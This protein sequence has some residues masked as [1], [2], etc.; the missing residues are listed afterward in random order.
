[1]LCWHHSRMALTSPGPEITWRFCW[2]QWVIVE[3]VWNL[4]LQSSKVDENSYMPGYASKIHFTGR[5][6]RDSQSSARRLVF[7]T[8]CTVRYVRASL[9]FRANRWGSAWVAGCV[10]ISSVSAPSFFCF[11]ISLI[12]IEDISLDCRYFSTRVFNTY[13][14]ENNA[15]KICRSNSLAYCISREPLL[16]NVNICFKYEGWVSSRSVSTVWK[17]VD[18]RTRRGLFKKVARCWTRRT[19]AD[20]SIELWVAFALG[21]RLLMGLFTLSN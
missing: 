3:E 17:V 5:R 13:F 4:K 10:A 18:L 16:R 1:M 2:P 14:L 19:S 20:L 9:S 12:L 15:R 8:H 11:F 21:Q 7:Q 6:V